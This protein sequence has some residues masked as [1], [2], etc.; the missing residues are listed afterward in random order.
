MWSGI[1]FDITPITNQATELLNQ[2]MPIVYVVG[3]VVVFGLVML[4][5]IAV[6]RRS[7]G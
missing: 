7:V 3:G 1:V 6:A 5:I 4:V 2:F